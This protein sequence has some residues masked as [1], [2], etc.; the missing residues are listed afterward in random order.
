M[1]YL[2]YVLAVVF[3]A[4]FSWQTFKRREPIVKTVTKTEISYRDTTIYVDRPVPKHVYHY[5]TDTVYLKAEID[6]IW[7]DNV[8]VQVPIDKQIYEGKIDTVGTYRAIVSGYKSSL[9]TIQFQLHFPTIHTTTTITKRPRFTFGVQAG[10][11][12]QYGLIDRKFD[13]GP[14]VGVGAQYNF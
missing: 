10:F 1:K 5:K 7:V 9:D 8:L 13:T 12:V 6:S 4:L 11:G 3:L 14:Y 2:G